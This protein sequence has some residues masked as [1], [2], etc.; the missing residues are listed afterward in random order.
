MKALAVDGIYALIHPILFILSEF[1]SNG[2][3]AADPPLP[4]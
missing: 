2:S 4:R 3:G 1:D